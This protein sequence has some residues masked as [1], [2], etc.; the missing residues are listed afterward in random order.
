MFKHICTEFSCLDALLLEA[1]LLDICLLREIIQIF[2]LVFVI[3]QVPIN[4]MTFWERHNGLAASQKRQAELEKELAKEY[5]KGK[6]L[7]TA[8]ELAAKRAEP[9][10]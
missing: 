6:A 1:D 4:R 2:K 9:R 8:L 7:E 5:K 3:L 10:I